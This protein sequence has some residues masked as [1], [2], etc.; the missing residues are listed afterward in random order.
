MP[1]EHHRKIYLL[2]IP[3]SHVPPKKAVKV[4]KHEFCLR[5]H[6][7]FITEYSPSACCLTSA[8]RRKWMNHLDLPTLA[9][10]CFHFVGTF[11]QSTYLL[12]LRESALGTIKSFQVS[13]LQCCCFNCLVI[14]Q[15]SMTNL[16]CNC[17]D[18]NWNQLVLM[19]ICLTGIIRYYWGKVITAYGRTK[20]INQTVIKKRAL[21]H[22]GSIFLNVVGT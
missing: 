18:E 21:R 13:S 19:G 20:A 8:R 1:I 4:I 2:L 10:I 5:A 17:C 15:K 3:H 7:E 11:Q 6:Q 22:I 14:I 16:C 12:K 9:F